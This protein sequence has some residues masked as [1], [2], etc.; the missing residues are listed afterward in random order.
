M[1]VPGILCGKWPLRPGLLFATWRAFASQDV[2]EGPCAVLVNFVLQGDDHGSILP[3]V[4]VGG[5]RCATLGHGMKGPVVEH[6][7][8]PRLL[9]A[10]LPSVHGGCNR[11]ARSFFGTANVVECLKGMAGWASGFIHL[12]AGGEIRDP[13]T[14]LVTGLVEA[15]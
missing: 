9:L 2:E 12:E 15:A 3:S 14:N 4:L 10:C 8:V 5:V 6:E 7:C 13:K 1:G 11:R